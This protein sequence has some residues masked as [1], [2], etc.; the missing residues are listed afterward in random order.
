MPPTSEQTI[1]G[2]LPDYELRQIIHQAYGDD[3]STAMLTQ[4]LIL[5]LAMFIRTEPQLF[6]EMLRLRVGLI[7]QVVN[8]FPHSNVI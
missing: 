1:T 7:I 6:L 8:R 3:Q 4:E 2:A 5:Y